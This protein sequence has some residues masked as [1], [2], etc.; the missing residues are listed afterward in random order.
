MFYAQITRKFKVL[1]IY[2]GG[3]NLSNYK[4]P[5]PIIMADHPFHRPFN[6]TVIWG[7]LMGLKIYGGLRFTIYK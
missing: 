2:I 6:A 1:D 4:Q 7:P 3:E 5:N